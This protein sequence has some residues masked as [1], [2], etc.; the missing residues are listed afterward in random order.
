M[1]IIPWILVALGTAS[2]IAGR[3]AT[4]DLTEGRALIAGWP[5]WLIAIGLFL[6]AFI[7]AEK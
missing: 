3:V 7:L 1:K 4:V 2:I 6:F 5:Y